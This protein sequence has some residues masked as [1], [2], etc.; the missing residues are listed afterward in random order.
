MKY[1]EFFTVDVWTVIFTWRN[2]LILY[3]IVKKLLFKPVNNMLA[4][5]ENEI[6]KIYDDAHLAD[7]KAK[8]LE[9]EYSEKMANAREEAG[10][11]IKQATESAQRR[12]DEIIASAQEKA[13]S[14]MQKAQNE[15]AQ[16][17]KKAYREIKGEISD[18]SV[19]IAGRMV[20]RELTATDHE[21]L[22]Q[23]FIENVGEEQ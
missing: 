5:R 3:I 1:L 4:R 21:A 20:Q 11:I 6:K 17:R 10:G 9:R 13:A 18:I 12:Q 19:A 8:N 7:E 14:I 2:M 22:I 23:K 15:I 16:E